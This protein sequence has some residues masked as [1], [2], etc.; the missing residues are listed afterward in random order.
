MCYTVPAPSNVKV[1]AT[2]VQQVGE[3]LAL[4]C[5][6]TSVKGIT[7]RVD[8]VWTNNDSDLKRIEG[9]NISTTSKNLA[10]YTTFYNILQL[11]ISDDGR[12]FYCEVFVNV[13]PSVMATGSL[14]LNVT[15]KFLFNLTVYHH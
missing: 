9:A 2:D 14:T 11:S 12:V 5:S 10:I 1:T 13:T 4:Q 6:V 15:G 8:I 7:S 3:T